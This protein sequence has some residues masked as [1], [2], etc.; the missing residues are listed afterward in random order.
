M[1]HSHPCNLTWPPA[2]TDALWGLTG[3]NRCYGKSWGTLEGRLTNSPSV[4]K[5]NQMW[6]E[7]SQHLP[8]A[9]APQ[10]SLPQRW[11]EGVYLTLMTTFPFLPAPGTRLAPPEPLL[12]MS[13][14]KKQWWLASLALVNTTWETTSARDGILHPRRW[15]PHLLVTWICPCW[16]T[17]ITTQMLGIQLNAGITKSAGS[18]H[19]AP[20]CWVWSTF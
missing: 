12:T 19:A 6:E 4:F 15:L 11:E 9:G 18:E 17:Q 8:A 13:T 10:L 7:T 14:S 2:S 16:T 3:D 20:C 1:S 5:I